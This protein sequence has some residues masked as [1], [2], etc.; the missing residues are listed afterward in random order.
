MVTGTVLV[1][2]VFCVEKN[3]PTI[4]KIR[5]YVGSS[6]AENPDNRDFR[7]NN[8]NNRISSMKKKKRK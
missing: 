4:L 6:D 5:Q 3:E 8:N 7:K 2:H 1:N